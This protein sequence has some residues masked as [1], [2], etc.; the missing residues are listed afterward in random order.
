MAPL[1]G[2]ERELGIDK[3]NKAWKGLAPEKQVALDRPHTSLKPS[4][5]SSRLSE[6]GPTRV[7]I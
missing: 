1:L 6:K 4:G 3:Q 5:D 7:M 2:I